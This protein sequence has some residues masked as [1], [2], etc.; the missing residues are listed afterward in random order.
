MRLQIK[1]DV[2]AQQEVPVCNARHNFLVNPIYRLAVD[3]NA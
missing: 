1:G 3:Y 2:E